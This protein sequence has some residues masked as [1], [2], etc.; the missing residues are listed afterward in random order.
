MAVKWVKGVLMNFSIN[1]NEEKHTKCKNLNSSYGLQL[2]QLA[3]LARK[4]TL[5]LLLTGE[6]KPLLVQI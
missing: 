6:K 2:F 4:I 3:V 1:K 5:E